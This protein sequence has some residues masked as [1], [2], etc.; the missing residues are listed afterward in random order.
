MSAVAPE[1]ARTRRGRRT[2]LLLIALFVGPILVALVFGVLGMKPA[3][4]KNKGERLQPYADLRALTPQLADGG[5]YRWNPEQ[6]LWRIA[7]VAPAG[8]ATACDK[9][10]QDID[11]VWQL[12][13]KDADRAQV[14][15]I[16]ELP[17]AAP[18]SPAW[19]QVRPEPALLEKLPR[20]R[21]AAGAPVTYAID[22]Y[23]FVVLRYAPGFDPG[24]LRSDMAKLLKLM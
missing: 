2:L 1:A 15:W 20:S 21:D 18:R 3:I 12:F 8:C 7:V 14:L 22:P 10:A 13:G 23:G 16:G 5:A 6:R 11:K 24:D 19:K 17:A 4:S 9:L